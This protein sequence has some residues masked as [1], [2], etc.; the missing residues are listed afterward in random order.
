MK[1]DI[2]RW[3]GTQSARLCPIFFCRNGF[4][5]SNGGR[6]VL[7]KLEENRFDIVKS[8]IASARDAFFNGSDISHFFREG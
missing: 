2:R 5:A 3:H 7:V 6:Q 4:A 1:S 8:K